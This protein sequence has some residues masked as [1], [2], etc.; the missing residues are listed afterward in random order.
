MEIFKIYRIK[1]CNIESFIYIMNIQILKGKGVEYKEFNL[2]Y[3]YILLKN[4]KANL[5]VNLLTFKS[6]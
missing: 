6:P 2:R 4:V 5:K 1:R 3:K